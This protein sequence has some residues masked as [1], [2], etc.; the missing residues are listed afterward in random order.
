MRYP[1][2]AIPQLRF[3][4]INELFG[5]FQCCLNRGPIRDISPELGVIPA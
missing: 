3:E 4:F 5:S 1:R 2:A